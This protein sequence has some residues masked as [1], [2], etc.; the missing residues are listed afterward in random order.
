MQILLTFGD[1]RNAINAEKKLAGHNIPISVMPLPTQ[2]GAGCGL[3]LRL[4]ES[5]LVEALTILAAA[6]IQVEKPYSIKQGD[7]GVSYEAL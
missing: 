1:T 3:S 5:K 4:D 6:G 7:R 2:L